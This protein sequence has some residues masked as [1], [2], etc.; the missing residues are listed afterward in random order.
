MKRILSLLLVVVMLFCLTACENKRNSNPTGEN[1]PETTVPTVY[2][3]TFD[4]LGGEAVETQKV[5]AGHAATK[6]V[7]PTKEGF[8][9]VEWQLGG[10]AYDFNTAISE[11]I[12]LTAYYT[13]NEE[14][15]TI[16]VDFNADNGSAIQT[17]QI[18][19]G[20]AV[21]EPSVPQKVGY[22]FVGWYNVESVFN[23]KTLLEED[24][25]LIAKW[26]VNPV[27]STEPTNKTTTT[28]TTPDTT[29]ENPI[30]ET[31]P[32]NPQ[33]PTTGTA[34][35]SI[36]FSDVQGKWYAEGTDDVILE[37][38]LGSDDTWVYLNSTN[39]DYHTGKI[40]MHVGYGGGEYYNDNGYFT[41]SDI[42][43]D[44]S[45]KLTY[46]KSNNTITFYRQKDYPTAK[47]WP[48][49]ILLRE[50][51][52]Y[53]WYLEGYKY[54]YLYP[55]VIPWYD[56]KALQWE[57]KNIHI[58]DNSLVAY[59]N[60]DK[61]AYREVDSSASSDTHNTLM[62]NPIEY[63]DSLIND[64]GMK[65]SGN[66]LYMTIGGI[67]YTFTRSSQ[68]KIVDVVLDVGVTDLVVN[69]GEWITINLKVSPWWQ[70][71]RFDSSSTGA[72][73]GYSNGV[74]TEDGAVTF[75]F[76]ASVA[77]NG[78]ITIKETQYGIQKTINVTVQATPVSGVSL[79]KTAIELSKGQTE[80]LVA[81]VA[82]DNASDSEV[83]W[84]TA[85][86]SIATV[87]SSGV[88]TANGHGTTTITATTR[89]GNFTASCQVTVKQS[90]LTVDASI[91][92]S[93]RFTSSGMTQGV[94]VTIEANGGSEIYVAYSIKLYYEG[95][96]VG[97]VSSEEMFASPFKNGTYTAEVYVKDSDGN[98]ASKTETTTISVSTS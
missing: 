69:E 6:P 63:A 8:S 34:S 9:F 71:Y 31:T 14:S 20:T 41:T 24:T 98:E 54:T 22:S 90:P 56:H 94:S 49:E 25:V 45:S 65:V 17:V 75:N 70:F 58:T 11:D 77:G 35:Q 91:G 79:N 87:S 27:T 21:T 30:T 36:K 2:M 18:A 26:K 19:K 67:Q 81:S 72:V 37:F 28:P 59:E 64:Y 74:V 46:T 5:E 61:A 76:M 53:Y 29:T 38:S 80:T 66:K 97:E 47:E 96:Y 43:L 93:T 12:T 4:S 39:F 16:S 62:V 1:E 40:E 78:T 32:T 7:D 92:L 68:K 3:V 52:G 57:S 50:I 44:S 15:K 60:F 48:H 10:Y 13:L 89:D 51:N 86:S 83:Y 82:P 84:S 55:T 73:Q 85:D 95:E 88:V 23:F 42:V 33:D